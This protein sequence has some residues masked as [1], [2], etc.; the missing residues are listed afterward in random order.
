MVVILDTKRS[1]ETVVLLACLCFLMVS[2]C[3]MLLASSPT[4]RPSFFSLPVWTEEFSKNLLGLKFH[5]GISRYSASWN[6]QLDLSSVQSA[7][8]GL[9]R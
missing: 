8:V 7:T 1:K 3:T 5:V 4:S 6:K 2:T 9:T